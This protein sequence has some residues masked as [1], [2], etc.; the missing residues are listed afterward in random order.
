M[1]NEMFKFFIENKLISSN[2]SGFEPSDFCINQLVSITH[3]IYKSFDEG[4][5]VRSV[6]RDISNTFDK[7]WR[8]GIIFKL[9][10]NGISGNLL[11]LLHDFLSERR[12]RVVLNG[13]ASTWTNVTAGVPQGSILCTLLFLI[14]INDLSEGLSTNAKLFAEDTSSFSV[15]HDSHTSPNV[16]NNDLEMIHNWAFQW[17]MNFN[18]D[19]TK[20]AQEVI[21]SYKTKKLPHPPLVFNNVNVTQSIYQKHLGIILDSKLTFE[22]HLNIVTT[23]IN[24]AIGLLCKLQNLLPRTALITIYKAFVRPHLDYGDILHDQAFNLSFQQ[25]LESMQYRACLAI[26]GAIWGTRREKIY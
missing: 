1:F 24:K 12:Q 18:P 23:K 17:K 20:Q 7:V 8:N 5:E 10:Q 25:K 22:N 14:Y 26:T 9:T 16:L 4:H 21:F 2:Q 11:K 19:P 13:Q 6:F 15:I 3:E